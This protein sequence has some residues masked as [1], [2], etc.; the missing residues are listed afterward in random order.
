M[1]MSEDDGKVI[2]P[3]C[4]MRVSPESARSKGNTAHHHGTEYFFCNPKCRDKFV[5]DAEKYLQ[6]PPPPEIRKANFAG[7]LTLP[8]PTRGR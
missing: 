8:A 3:V 7:T 2:D 1:P 5:A 4:G 6:S